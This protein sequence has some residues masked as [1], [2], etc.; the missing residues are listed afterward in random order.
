MARELVAFD[1]H[2]TRLLAAR[3]RALQHHALRGGEPDGGQ[4][5]V[6]V[7]AHDDDAAAARNFAHF[8]EREHKQ[9]APR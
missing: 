4:P 1:D 2:D 7:E 6:V 9:P 3:L 8:R 5:L